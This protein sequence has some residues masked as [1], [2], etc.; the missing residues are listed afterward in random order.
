MKLRPFLTAIAT[1]TLLFT[2]GAGAV[3][4]EQVQPVMPQ[5]DVYVR[6]GET[7]LNSLSIE[8]ITATMDD[9]P[10]QVELLE[11]SE[12]GIF[13]V[14]ML[15]ISRSISEEYIAAARQAVMN[16]YQQMGQTDQLALI[17]FGNE[18]NVLLQGGESATEVQA[19]L[20]T[21]HSTDNNT[22]FYDAMNTLIETAS[23]QSN[24]RRVAVVVSDGVDDTDAGMTRDE[25]V[26]ILRQSGVAVYAMAVD[27]ADEEIINQFRDFIQVSGGD[28]VSFSPADASQ[29]LDSLQ[30]S[31]DEIW[32]LQLQASNNNADGQ[33]HKLNIQFGEL[34]NLSVDIRPTR[35]TPDEKPPYLISN[36]TDSITNTLTLTFNEAIANLNNPLCYIL[37]DSSGKAMDFTILS[38]DS[39]SVVLQCSELKDSTGWSLELQNLTDTSMEKNSMAPC[40]VPLA[41][42]QSP[43][44]GDS[45]TEQPGSDNEL[46]KLLLP[47]IGA[48]L[49]VILFVML[50]L[51]KSRQKSSPIPK[52]KDKKE[53]AEKST[54]PKNP[55]VKFFFENN[56][57][58][59][60]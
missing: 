43:S 18:V 32:H 52:K 38:S 19:A 7:D 6:D 3:S 27:S 10:L 15:D 16:T 48:L 30:S 23:T 8:D 11:P 58:P 37:K 26:D 36:V 54:A 29:K 4:L 44:S 55:G 22:R 39:T 60:Q 47:A 31:I 28:L 33:N 35:W 20:D 40:T 42:S 59:K 25:L 53:K 5:I 49:I 45:T 1:T 56:E 50:L 17:S 12:Q 46:L 21:I 41:E 2:M 13:Y 57:K 14:F 51:V 34:D 9:T 24:M